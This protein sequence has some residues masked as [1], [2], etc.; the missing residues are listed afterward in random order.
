MQPAGRYP[1]ISLSLGRGNGLE[2]VENVHV[3]VEGA[4]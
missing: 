3:K 4:V 2:D 1:D